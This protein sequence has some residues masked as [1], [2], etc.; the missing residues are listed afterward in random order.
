MSFSWHG[1]EQQTVWEQEIVRYHFTVKEEVT[2]QNQFNQ[3]VTALPIGTHLK[4]SKR[5]AH[6]YF[7]QGYIEWSAM[8]YREDSGRWERRY[9]QIRNGIVSKDIETRV[10]KQYEVQPHEVAPPKRSKKK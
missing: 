3:T 7:T 5:E 1:R 10:L 2:V 8:S 9:F 4:I 6:K